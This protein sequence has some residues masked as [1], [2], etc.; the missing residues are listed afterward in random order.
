MRVSVYFDN[1][2]NI[3]VITD[4]LI[5]N[6]EWTID[7]AL[8]IEKINIPVEVSISFVDN[9]EIQQLN[10]QYREKDQPTDVLSFPLIEREQLNNGQVYGEILLGDIIISIPRAK[11]QAIEYGHSFL[12]EMAYLTVHGM[13]HLLGYDHMKPE[14]KALMREKEELVMNKA[15]ITR[16]PS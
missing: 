14:E 4:E 6:L 15:S 11:E 9:H 1:R 8:K 16:D 12:R 2:Q 7:I 3:E 5:K 10:R 13:F